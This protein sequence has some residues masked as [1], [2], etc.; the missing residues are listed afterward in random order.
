MRFA[1]V[2]EHGSPRMDEAERARHRARISRIF[3]LACAKAQPPAGE[4]R[5]GGHSRSLGR[6]AQAAL[7][8]LAPEYEGQD[9]FWRV[10]W[11]EILATAVLEECRDVDWPASL[12]EKADRVW[13]TWKALR[14]ERHAPPSETDQE[15]MRETSS[16]SVPGRAGSKVVTI[17]G[18][19]FKVIHMAIP[20][21]AVT[22]LGLAVS[23]S[24]KVIRVSPNSPVF[25]C[26]Q[27]GDILRKV[28]GRPA[29]TLQDLHPQAGEK[30]D[31]EVHRPVQQDTGSQD[32]AA[33]LHSQAEPAQ[34]SPVTAS[35]PPPPPPLDDWSWS[36]GQVEAPPPPP[37][38]QGQRSSSSF[39]P[40]PRIVARVSRELRGPPPPPPSRHPAAASSSRQ[41]LPGAKKQARKYVVLS[42][43]DIGESAMKCLFYTGKS[44]PWDALENAVA[45]YKKLGRIPQVVIGQN[46]LQRAP[47]TLSKELWDSFVMC[48]VVDADNV[49]RTVVKIGPGDPR[50]LAL[51]LAQKYGCMWVDNRPYRAKEWESQD[52]W[53]WLRGFGLAFKVE[54]MF[55]PLGN[56]IP[57]LYEEPAF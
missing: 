39:Q 52:I 55:D 18:A 20:M 31:L 50:H 5:C 47:S 38:P 51:T 10:D 49:A 35:T 44:L 26:I 8:A 42:A 54:H 3:R 16:A 48:P 4:Q 32:E 11:G 14:L 53:P 7:D 37:P 36:G 25:G 30:Y 43:E 33:Q 46:S 57:S 1:E 40:Q 24:L 19:M 41:H 12:L 56:F 34:S 23:N 45:F 6:V 13:Q 27:E 9:W 15:P 21:P 17:D 22:R 28:N 29:E 2:T